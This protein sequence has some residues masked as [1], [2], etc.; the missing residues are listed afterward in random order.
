M[1]TA[2]DNQSTAKDNQITAIY[3]QITAIG[4]DRATKEEQIMK[5]H[6]KIADEGAS[7]PATN[8]DIK[9][10]RYKSTAK[11]SVFVFMF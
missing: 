10:S 4:K 11:L 1:I 3:N 5:F 9:M 7:V 6:T 2:K 8:G